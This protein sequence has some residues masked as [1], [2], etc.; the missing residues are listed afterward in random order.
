V[1]S[2]SLGHSAMMEFRPYWPDCTGPRELSVELRH[3]SWRSCQRYGV[4]IS[5]KGDVIVMHGRA[6]QAHYQ[7]DFWPHSI[8]VHRSDLRVTQHRVLPTGLRCAIEGGDL[9]CCSHLHIG[10]G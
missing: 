10:S 5:S 8:P 4:L 7:V 1:A 9:C 3:V 6:I 2:L